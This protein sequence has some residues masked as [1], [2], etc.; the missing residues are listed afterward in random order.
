MK[1]AIQL[2]MLTITLL[3]SMICVSCSLNSQI[4]RANKLDGVIRDA[5]DYLDRNLEP[6]SSVIF[7]NVVS[8]YPEL[9]KYIIDELITNAVNDN[10]FSVVDRSQLEEIMA[11]QDFQL[12]GAVDD[13]EAVK[14]GKLAGAQTIISGS[15]QEIGDEFR[16]MVRALSVE[17]ATV[18]AQDRWDMEKDKKLEALAVKPPPPPS[19][20]KPWQTSGTG[21]ATGGGGGG[22][23]TIIIQSGGATTTT[24]P[25]T[26]TYTPPTTSPSTT[27]VTPPSSSTTTIV[28]PPSTPP[29]TIPSPSTP[30]AT[31]TTTT[32]PSTTP[33]TT[34]TPPP[35][36]TT[37]PPVTTPPAP[38]PTPAP[39]PAPAPTPK[40]DTP[41]NY[42]IKAFAG[43]GFPLPIESCVELDV[44][45]DMAVNFGLAM[46]FRLGEGSPLWLET[47]LGMMMHTINEYVDYYS[48]DYIYGNTDIDTSYL[49]AVAKLKYDIP[50]GKYFAI[51]PLIGYE[52]GYLME[53]S[54]Y[55][56]SS[57]YNS[58]YNYDSS[59]DDYNSLSHSLKTGVD[60]MFWKTIVIGTEFN[61]GLSN[62][63]TDKFT[64]V[65]INSFLFTFGLRYGW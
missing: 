63:Y 4:S 40:P 9:S 14:I 11:E 6:E 44:T 3:V 56:Y 5:S 37:T 8:E 30:P 49:T 51:Q 57:S 48:G 46:E 58:S 26:S 32:P 33:T 64:D 22:N 61:Y 15:M 41:D 54:D 7:L 16:L 31:T 65:K 23:T 52:V 59:I 1:K 29:T 34:T 50:I 60:F 17:T 20:L 35:P 62:L 12:S 42:A 39:T 28:T 36:P 45:G 55:Y 38:E 21:L 25:S 2:L 10:N 47:G 24:S 19:E 13:D 43:V 27:V 53:V 18:E